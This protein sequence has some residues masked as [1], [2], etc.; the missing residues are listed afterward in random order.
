MVLLNDLQHSSLRELAR[1][2]LVIA[3]NRDFGYNRGYDVSLFHPRR[4]SGPILSSADF[5]S[6]HR[7]E[8]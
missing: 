2:R 4:A 5:V 6:R 8:S 1:Q 3:K 7:A